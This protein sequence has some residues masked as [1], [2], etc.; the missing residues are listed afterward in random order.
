M[1]SATYEI[2]KGTVLAVVVGQPG[3]DS[4]PGNG[5][6]GG[7]SG[8]GGS[9]VW[10]PDPSSLQD[11]FTFRASSLSQLLIAGGGGGGSYGS[12][13]YRGADGSE[14]TAGTRGQSNT[15]TGGSNG[16]GGNVGG[17]SNDNSGGAGAGWL[18][19]RFALS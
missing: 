2:K 17:N 7:G 15:G 10:L 19:V 16:N 4:L 1:A 3:G 9:F 18:Q 11:P 8:G 13:S 6:S 14:L 12:A 5:Y